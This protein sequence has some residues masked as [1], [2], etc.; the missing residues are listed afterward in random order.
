MK[1]EH[2]DLALGVGR[3]GLEAAAAHHVQGTKL[4]AAAKQLAAAI[5]CRSAFHQ[6]VDQAQAIKRHHSMQAQLLQRT[7]GATA[8]QAGKVDDRVAE[9]AHGALAT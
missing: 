9:L 3:H 8:A 7:F 5:Q 2:L 1:T 6:L 4:L